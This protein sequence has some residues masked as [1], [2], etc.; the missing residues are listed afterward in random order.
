M[1]PS[2]PGASWQPSVEQLLALVPHPVFWKDR[3]GVYRGCNDA[4]ARDAGLRSAAE[5]VGKTDFDLWRPRVVAE[6]YRAEDRAVMESRQPRRGIVELLQR[7]DGTEL[8]VETTRVPLLDPD[9]QPGGVLGFYEDI[10]ARK[11][12]EEAAQQERYFSESALEAM[13][14]VF[15]V[16]DAQGRMLKWN[17]KLETL[18]GYTAE[19]I[20]ERT[21]LDLLHP[22]CRELVTQRVQDVFSQ[23]WAVA[24][25]V[26][27][28]KD[29]YATPYY[30]HSLRTIRDG[31]P[32]VM[33]MGI[34]ISERKRGEDLVQGLN[35][36]K[37]DLLGEGDLSAKLRHVTDGV[38]R[39]FDADFAR[40]WLSLPGDRCATDCVHAGVAEGPHV[41][42][43]RERCLHLVA[44][45]GRYTHLD[46]AMHRRVPFGCYKIGRIASG[47]EPS[48][49][50][51]TVAE[52]PRVHD[53]EWARQLG[54]AS[55]AGYR[56][57]SADQEP[58][59][60][61]ALFSRHPLSAEDDRLLASVAATASQVILA[62][63][64]QES[65]RASEE[66]WQFALEGAGDGV[67][68][69]NPQTG[70][71]IC[72]RQW[73][74]ML[75]Y[76]EHEINV[77]M[78][79]WE[80]ALHPDDRARALA[81]L[82]R[83]LSGQATTYMSEY[84]MRCKDG[85]W[86]WILDRGKVVSYTPEGQPLRVVGTH[87]DLTERKRVE[88]A[89]QLN[90]SRLEALLELNQKTDATLADIA[91]F[92][93][94]QAVR[95]TRSRLGYIAFVNEDE[96]VL[97]MFAWSK[98]AMAECAVQNRPVEYPLQTTGLWGEAVRQRRS[99]ITNNY[100]APSP[101][102]KGT[103]AGHVTLRR[104]MNVPVFDGERI[105]IV[106]GVGN[107]DT[108]YDES[109]V[110]Q[111]TLLMSGMWRSVQRTRA[112]EESRA[113][114]ARFRSLYASMAEGVALHELVRNEH[115]IPVDYRLL[116]VNPRYEQV[117]G[118]SAERVVG[119]LAREAYGTPEPPYLRE[120]AGAVEARQPAGLETYFASLARHFAISIAPLEGDRFATIFFDITERKQAEEQ[121]RR[122]EAELRR[123][124]E[125]LLRL[126]MDGALF[127]GELAAALA[128]I[129]A[130]GAELL[131]TER[132][133][134]WWYEDEYRT[135]R[136]VDAFQR[137]SGQHARGETL[138]SADFPTYTASHRKG[139]VIA[140]TDVRSDPRTRDIPATYW[141]A[142]DIASLVDAPVWLHGRLG[143][144]VS[145]EHVG[146]PRQWSPDDERLAATLATL[147]SL[148]VE[149]AERRRSEAALRDSEAMLQSIFRAAPVAIGIVDSDRHIRSVNDCIVRI[150]GYRPAE[151]IGRD[152][153]HLYFTAEEYELAGR[154]FQQQA[155]Q[156]DI[157]QTEHRLRRK[158][159]SAVHVMVS[160]APLRREDASAGS[161][162]T[163][164]DITERKRAEQA[165]QSRIVAMTRPL[166]DTTTLQFSDLFDLAEIQKIQDAFAESSGVAA[167]ITDPDGVPLTRPSG[168]CR[169]CAE[170]VRKSP[171][172][173]QRCAQSDAELG[174][175][176]AAGLV[177]RPCLSAGLWGAGASIT[178]GGKHIANWLIGQVRDE[179]LDLERISQYAR[180][181]DADPEEF[182]RALLEVPVMSAAQFRKVAHTLS[183]L[184][185]QL[186]IKAY[187]N[188]QQARFI[189][190]LKRAEDE[191]DRLFN[192]S[193]DLLCVAGFDGRLRQVNPAWT[194]ALG[195]SAEELTKSPWLEFVHPAD[196][197]ATIAAGERLRRGLE[198]R[199]FENRYRCKDGAYR[200]LSWNSYPLMEQELIFAVS[201]DVTELKA[202]AEERARLEVQLR[203]AQKMEAVGQLA[204]G[205]AHDFNNIL[206]AVFGQ[207]DLAVQALKT[208]YPT[209][210][211]LL[212]GMHQI[213]RSA[214]RASALTRQLLAFSRRQVI[215][216]EVLNLNATLR[217]LEK[218][219]RRLLTENITLKQILAPDLAATRADAGQLEQVI[220][221]LVVN[222]RDAMPNGGRLT[223]ETG[224]V[225]LDEAYAALHPGAQPGEHVVLAV[226]DTGHGM[227]PATL[228]RIFE[229][230]FTTKPK[231]QG[232]GLG[233]STVYGIVKQAGG[234][235]SVYSERGKGT[236][237][238]V[239]LPAVHEPVTLA[240]PARAE[241]APPGGTETLMICEDDPAVREMTARM[242]AGAGYQ[243][244]VAPDAAHAL[245]LAA[246][247]AGPLAL[248]ITD[249]IM[250]DMNG[251]QLAEALT[252]VRPGVRTLFVS[253][254]TSNVIAHH[255]VL[256]ESVD[257]LEKPYSRRQLLQRVREMLD[258]AAPP[259]GPPRSRM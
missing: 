76:A 240:K 127:G 236:T 170:F 83:H 200:W 15:F 53:R 136:C 96:S 208:Q 206:T 215:R 80:Q 64:I 162:F 209:A 196:V 252:G 219:L 242:L 54:L 26:V 66:R 214:H 235:V 174:R 60:V 13:P 27:V 131:Q 133:S 205:V 69:W 40:I 256:D 59:G 34:D 101:W 104:H 62:A 90:E 39:L 247:H 181:L 48:F 217:D 191:R 42:R 141:D 108:D 72:S 124:T 7:V 228:E 100:A 169:L 58:I 156:Q 195:W 166:D 177:V 33:G 121:Q 218:M 160:G 220:V 227:D 30:C 68:D 244:L 241:S 21:I 123:Q 178:V 138:R 102:K 110:R 41:C 31:R 144:L 232:T 212:D 179:S 193:I 203:Q 17:R 75:G 22:D 222:A 12:A 47:D 19:E 116:E 140:A 150:L 248:L 234:H 57:L 71:I 89:L 61:L 44:S 52:D 249:V 122:R 1:E 210:R 147:V 157:I 3:D 16:F 137:R 165:L 251:R 225:V 216:P 114:E 190:D 167:L 226:S 163:L 106:A 82:H 199:S 182:R 119:K 111:L 93:M 107:K 224:N 94:E 20:A 229:P 32:C 245:E 77:T 4:F 185:N 250:P 213:E 180:E 257:F 189:A 23:G 161:V 65:L 87:T 255:G 18:T 55:F 113:S 98:T 103:P 198:V 92:A 151:V 207:L 246:A 38:V 36:L 153:R 258:R 73:K 28:S 95:L 155:Q 172:G 233:L 145:F 126:M 237:F 70:A 176:S 117:T 173:R 5:V 24:E 8:W 152:M 149:S 50:T 37:E 221:N 159:G 238:K 171:K 230:F 168:F 29:G 243:V 91:E 223:L 14:G 9:G 192:S 148:C 43:R 105:V 63:Q 97:T 51:N 132:V 11:Q 78:A 183:V 2:G 128:E 125:V 134:V 154:T 129:T 120:F 202:A 115:G 135:I 46:G 187:Q 10:T 158:D 35:R 197:P 175:V 142:H 56:L 254:Y 146:A 67:W 231:G 109:D 259:A 239:H 201:R 194:R 164:M 74:A 25:V 86:K 112:E 99:I 6:G 88:E 84:R 118:L 130:A 79:W 184:S 253:G 186:S 188:V 211:N 143:G 81:D 45:S 85:S 49:L 204:G 139:Q